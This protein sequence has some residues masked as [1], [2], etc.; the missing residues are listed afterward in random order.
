MPV[1]GLQ[2]GSSEAGGLKGPTRL[3]CVKSR[4]LPRRMAPLSRLTIPS[5]EDVKRDYLQLQ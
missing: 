2:K 4:N 1:P 5:L 3:L